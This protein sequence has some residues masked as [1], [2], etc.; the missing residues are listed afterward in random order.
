MAI[1]E[2]NR[3]ARANRIG[4]SDAPTIMSANDFK[5]PLALYR[6]KAGID[7]PPDLDGKMAIIMGNALEAGIADAWSTK[8]GLSAYEDTT[9]Y[10]STRWDKAVSHIDGRIRELANTIIEIKCRGANA[11]QGYGP[12]GGDGGDVLAYDFVQIQHHCFCGDWDGCY[13]VAYFG[14]ADLRSYYVERDDVYIEKMLAAEK[15]FWRRVEARE[16]PELDLRHRTSPALVSQMYPA[17][18]GAIVDLGNRGQALHQDWLDAKERE[19]TAKAEA[20]QARLELRSL[21]GEAAIGTLPGGGSYRRKE[22]TRKPYEVSGKT[23]VDFR[24]TKK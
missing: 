21:V 2:A 4:S 18:T 17:I 23:V 7:E 20:E 24:Y 13:L 9:S 19:K 10:V 8:M 16:P 6:E 5:T 1:S 11:A 3:Q 12:D 22:I 15:E 14:G